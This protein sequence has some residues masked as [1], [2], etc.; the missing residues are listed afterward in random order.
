M[1]IFYFVFLTVFATGL[2]LSPNC[3]IPA[4]TEGVNI[5]VPYAQET[6]AIS[7][8]STGEIIASGESELIERSTNNN[9]DTAARQA[10]I[11]IFD[12]KLSFALLSE[13]SCAV[14]FFPLSSL[15]FLRTLSKKK[16][17]PIIE[18]ATAITA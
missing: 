2:T 7:E 12:I 9:T 4:N 1:I 13:S 8:Q 3:L 15:R 5:V 11:S 10:C 6:N 14:N 17:V 18:R 16:H